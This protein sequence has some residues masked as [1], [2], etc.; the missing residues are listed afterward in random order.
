M[1]AK[2]EGEDVISSKNFI[3]FYT[4]WLKLM[5]S[6]DDDVIFATYS[7]DEAFIYDTLH[8]IQQN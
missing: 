6:K 2:I 7:S 4:S 3:L 1:C 8:L 5:F